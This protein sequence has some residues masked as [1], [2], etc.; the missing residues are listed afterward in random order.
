MTVPT[1]TVPAVT[2]VPGATSPPVP[3]DG[4]ST[5]SDEPAGPSPYDATVEQPI[6]RVAATQKGAPLKATIAP[7]PGN[8]RDAKGRLLPGHGGVP[9][10][11]RPKGLAARV[12]Q[13]V[14]FDKAIITLQDIAWGKLAPSARMADR[15]KAIEILMDRGHG[16]PQVTI[17][18]KEG[19]TSATK[20]RLQSMTFEQLVTMTEGMRALASGVSDDASDAD[21]VEE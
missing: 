18:I 16:K 15:L 11:G 12:R 3:L 8:G 20:Q 13:L 17:D 4:D 19:G 9:G 14:D 21:I 10:S 7:V 2:S 6:T 1:V 5:Q